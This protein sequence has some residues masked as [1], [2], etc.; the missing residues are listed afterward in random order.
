MALHGSVLQLERVAVA[1]VVGVSVV[2]VVP[3]PQEA[4]VEVGQ[5][6]ELRGQQRAVVGGMA[7][8]VALWRGALLLGE[9]AEG[10]RAVHSPLRHTDHNL[11]GR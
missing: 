8:G 1:M 11:L 4:L 6:C 10:G 9:G 2:M 7:L 3:T 5:G